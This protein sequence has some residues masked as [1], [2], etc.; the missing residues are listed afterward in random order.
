MENSGKLN[1][2]VAV[3]TGASKV[4]VFL[5]SEDSYWIHGETIVVAGGQR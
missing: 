4:A 1:G 3:I 2:K 5:A